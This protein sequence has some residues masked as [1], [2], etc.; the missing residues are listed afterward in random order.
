MCPFAS[1]ELMGPFLDA[2]GG[3]VLVYL[4]HDFAQFHDPLY[5]SRQTF[6]DQFCILKNRLICREIWYIYVSFNKLHWDDF[7]IK[8]K[9]E[10]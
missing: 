2:Y 6:R 1:N 8:H 7:S 10:K 5:K 3:L 9:L 4:V